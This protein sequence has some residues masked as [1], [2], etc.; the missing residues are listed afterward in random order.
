MARVTD[1]AGLIESDVAL[2]HLLGSVR[3]V[4]VLGIKTATQALQP[5]YE[6]PRYLCE[7]GLEVIPVPV[8]FPG[9]QS[10][11][12]RP[13][14]RSLQGIAGP[15]DLVNVFRRPQDLEAHLDD[16]LACGPRAVWLQLGIRHDAFAGRLVEAGI[17]VVQDRCLMVEH[18]RLL[19]RG[20]GEEASGSV[21]RR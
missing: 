8:Y 17:D 15:V 13:V 7:Q 18:R 19:G 21:P 4:A 12:G 16:V 2:T 9:V 14:F 6:V 1:L 11:L 20:A 10:I 3:R 5:A